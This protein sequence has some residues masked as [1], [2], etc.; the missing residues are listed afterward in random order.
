MKT[1]RRFSIYLMLV[2]FLSNVIAAEKYP[3]RPIRLVVANT[4]GSSADVMARIIA[5]G[6]SESFKWNVVVENKPGANGI[7]GIDMVAKAP[8]DGYTLG[9]VVP[10]LMTVNP[11]VYKNMPFR[12][13]EDL[14]P[15]TQTTSIVFA[16]VANPQLPFK[17][18][19]DLISFSKKMSVL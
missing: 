5:T 19:N 11:H 16:L 17:N 14:V 7:V 15:I 2:I 4:A 6:L 8:P 3:S 1:I 10:S 13:L 18:A 9:L 12:P